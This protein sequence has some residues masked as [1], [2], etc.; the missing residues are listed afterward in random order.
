MLISYRIYPLKLYV[1]LAHNILQVDPQ[2]NSG[3]VFIKQQ[4]NPA[5][6]SSVEAVEFTGMG[7]GNV[8]PVYSLEMKWS[9][10]QISYAS[11]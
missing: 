10:L 1:M 11:G 3:I 4:R 8:Q 6:V 5:V 9:T 2:K 7:K